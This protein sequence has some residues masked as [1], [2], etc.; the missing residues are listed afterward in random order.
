MA[1][2]EARRAVAELPLL[3]VAAGPRDREGWAER[4]KEEYRA[5]IQ[6]VENNKRA[7]N[8][9]FRL[10]SNAEGTRWFGRCWYVHEL[11]KYEFAIEFEIPVTYPSTAPEIAIPE[12]DGKTAKMYRR[13]GGGTEGAI[14]VGRG[15][16]CGAA[17]LLSPQLGPWLA[18]EIPDLV[19]KGIIQHKEK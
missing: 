10:E 14:T 15:C 9:W 3:R 1:M 19:A 5:L 12:L 18:V 4:L 6:Y 16:P 13:K 2:E 17:H 11:L 8:D 7:D